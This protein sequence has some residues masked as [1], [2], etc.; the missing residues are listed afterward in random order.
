MHKCLSTLVSAFMRSMVRVEELTPGT[1]SRGRVLISAS[2]L[3]MHTT[4]SK[5]SRMRTT[6]CT[7]A[8]LQ[9]IVRRITTGACW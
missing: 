7:C 1:L 6:A 2:T 8:R 4:E 5:G 9:I 3:T